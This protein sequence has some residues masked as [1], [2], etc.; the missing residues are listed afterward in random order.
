VHDKL[1]RGLAP[2]HGERHLRVGGLRYKDE[3]D[4]GVS[5]G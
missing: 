4:G 1:V 5:G 2:H 3:A